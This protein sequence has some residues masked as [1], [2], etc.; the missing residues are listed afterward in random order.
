MIKK[1]LKILLNKKIKE[2]EEIIE[3]CNIAQETL[4]AKSDPKEIS[5][6]LILKDKIL[7]HK[8]SILTLKELE[9]EF[10]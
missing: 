1:E 2:H 8:A 5:K 9:E 6:L 10:N 4:K 7:F 3:N